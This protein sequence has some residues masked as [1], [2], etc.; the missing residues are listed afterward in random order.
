MY[1]TNGLSTI[2]DSQA[3][4][5]L[6][7]PTCL[8][9]VRAYFFI[10]FLYLWII[11]SPFSLENKVQTYLI[12]IYISLSVMKR[13]FLTDLVMGFTFLKIICFEEKVNLYLDV[14][15]GFCFKR[16]WWWKQSPNVLS[17]C[18]PLTFMSERLAWMHL[19]FFIPSSQ[20]FESK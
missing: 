6:T 8:S 1:I 9:E 13:T 3:S 11:F 12:A 20:E 16:F 18:M 19:Q 15:N 7:W 17:K 2:H 10:M 14:E 5:S 4:V